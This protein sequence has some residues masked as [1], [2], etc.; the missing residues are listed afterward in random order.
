V[1]QESGSSAFLTATQVPPVPVQAWQGPQA[2]VQQKLSVQLPEAQ[3][4]AARQAMPGFFLHNPLASQVFAPV[5]V[6]ASSAFLTATQVP[7]EPVQSWQIPQV[8]VQQKP[9]VQLA[10]AQSP[11]AVQAMPGFFLHNPLASQV[12]APVQVLA[13]SAF[14]TATQV[15]PEPVQSW[16]IPQV[17]VQQKP[18]V[19]L[20]EAQSPAAVQAMPG[21]FLHNPLASQVFAPVQVLASSALFT[22]EH[23]PPVPTKLQARQAQVHEVLQQTPSTQNPPPAHSPASPEHACPWASWAWQTVPAIAEQ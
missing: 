19:Q 14:L 16:Q 22:A 8:C 23:V 5:Q 9:S 17:C 6:L 13:S 4:P 1:V 2:C 20:A 11:A 7:P 18:S 10:E 3:S 21:F 15:P 12:F